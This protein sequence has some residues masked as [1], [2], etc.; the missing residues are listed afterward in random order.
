M[1]DLLLDTEL[2]PEQTEYL[3][4]VK[5]SADSLLSIIN[6]ILDFSKLEAGK[7]ALENL[8]FDLRKSLGS[9]M[10]M[11]V[12]RAQE[13]GLEL[14]LDVDP[15][16][17]EAIVA[18]PGRL[19]QILVN[20]IGNALKFTD[21]GEVQVRVG[22]ESEDSDGLHLAFSVRDTGVGIPPE[23]QNVIFGAFTQ[24]DSST[25]RKYGGTGLG[26]AISVQLVSLMGGRLWIESK[27]GEGSNFQFTI[28]A[29]RAKSAL[30]PRSFDQ[31]RLVGEPVLIVDDNAANRRILEDSVRGWGMKPIAVERAMPALGVLLERRASGARLPLLVT[32]AHMP[33]LDGFGL[34]EKIREHRGLDSLRIVML[35]SAG[36]KG[37]ATRCKELGVA[38]YLSK[39]FDRLELRDVLISVLEGKRDAEEANQE[40]VTRHAVREQLRSLEIL[41][42]EDNVVNQRLITRL[43]EKRGH[44]SVVVKNGREA[45]DAIRG[46]AFD[47]VLM[48]CEMPELDGLEAAS[49]IREQEKAGGVHI[50][51]IALTAHAMRGDRERCIAAGMDGYISKPVKAE[52]LFSTIEAVIAGH[53][54]N[55][56]DSNTSREDLQ[57]TTD[58]I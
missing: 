23:K 46:Q 20:L 28:C 50:P 15:Q 33:E 8:P 14:I 29:G 38:G 55:H 45:I 39:P 26:L 3:E 34:V 51:I 56:S 13:K 2:S 10:K 1:T 25:T 32:D 27:I 57:P 42:A 37:D 19:R 41:V 16:V 18:D 17:P 40:P 58:A 47:A 9:V 24:A 5:G 4:M 11:L 22:L 44:R 21:R 35:T 31:S 6:D 30:A 48:D 43:L 49:E 12:F 53:S 54:S 52:E 7:V 36:Q